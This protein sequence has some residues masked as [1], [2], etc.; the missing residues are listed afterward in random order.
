VPGSGAFVS[1]EDVKN[2][3]RTIGYQFR[4]RSLLVEAVSHRAFMGRSNRLTLSNQRLEF[5]GDSILSYIV[6]SY[7]FRVYPG[8]DE[9]FLSK[10]RAKV[11]DNRFL[12]EVGRNLG[13]EDILNDAR[14]RLRRKTSGRL[15]KKVMGDIFESIIGA[16]YLDGGMD[17]AEEFI[18]R[19]ILG[20]IRNIEEVEVDFK[21]SLQEWCQ[22]NGIPL[23]EY[24][25]LYSKGP[26]HDKSFVVSVRVG[27]LGTATGEGQSKKEAEQEAARRIFELIKNE[28]N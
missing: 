5:L 23:P 1:E 24:S 13:I 16:V 27:T 8:K 15:S 21:T 22:K 28:E 7:L 20:K 17:A 14:K 11:V 3:E 6:S 2:L 10:L 19:A 4:D 18:E 12:A 25:L 9:G 26:E